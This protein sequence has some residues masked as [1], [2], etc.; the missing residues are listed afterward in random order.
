MLKA[1]VAEGSLRFR[2]VTCDEGYGNIPDFLD[3]VAEL[4]RWYFAEVPHST[5]VWQ[6]RPQTAVPTWSGRGRRPTKKR[7][8]AGEA[9]PMAV[10]E[11]AAV[12]PEEAWRA[13][14]IKEGSKGPMVA[15][16]AFRRVVAVRDGL[17][18][19]EV[20]LVLR[21][22]LAEEPELKTYLSNA[23]LQTADTDLVRVAG[24]RWPVET[25]IEEGKDDLG[26]SDYMVRTW[27]GWHHHMT[28]CILAHHYLVRVQKRL[29]GGLPH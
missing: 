26:M 1:V 6:S 21:R 20:W 23:P 13:F 15:L 28:E 11:I 29:K 8:A 19:P 16:F 5:R 9:G 18:G 12:I 4:G 7:L 22:S 10:N 14:C 24:L 17:P 27:L 3:S 2:W 25:A